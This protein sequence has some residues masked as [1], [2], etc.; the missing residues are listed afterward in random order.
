[1]K[2]KTCVIKREAT[3]EEKVFATR[4]NDKELASRKHKDAYKPE[5][6]QTAQRKM[7][8]KMPVQNDDQEVNTRKGTQSHERREKRSFTPREPPPGSIHLPLGDEP[9]RTTCCCTGTPTGHR[10]HERRRVQSQ[11][12]H[13]VHTKRL[14]RAAVP[15]TIW[16]RP[17]MTMGV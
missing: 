8:W 17:S 12:R 14:R 2:T 13:P 9:G 6:R 11:V 15:R 16:H 1:M 4:L 5:R 10:E 3:H 7:A